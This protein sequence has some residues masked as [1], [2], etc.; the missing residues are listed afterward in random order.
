M[1]TLRDE[2]S[3]GREGSTGHCWIN[4]PMYWICYS[5]ESTASGRSRSRFNGKTGI[6]MLK[7]HLEKVSAGLHAG[8]SRDCVEGREPRDHA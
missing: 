4:S 7:E 2:P 3:G 6:K 1:A 8:K 5:V